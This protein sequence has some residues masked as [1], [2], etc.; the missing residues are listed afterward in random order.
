M[1]SPPAP[2]SDADRPAAER[3]LPARAASPGTGLVENA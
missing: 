1:L 3:A 2:R